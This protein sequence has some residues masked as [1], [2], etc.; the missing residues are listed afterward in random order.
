MVINYHG[1]MGLQPSFYKAAWPIVG[2]EF[3]HAILDF[4]NTSMVLGKVNVILTIT[5]APK[6]ANASLMTQ[7]WPTGY[8]LLTLSLSGLLTD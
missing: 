8:Y 4:F 1:L 3:T 5:L 7:F 2:E 6:V